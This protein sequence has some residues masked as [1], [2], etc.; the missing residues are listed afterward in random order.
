M[1][2][3]VCLCLRAYQHICMFVFFTSSI[4]FYTAYLVC[5]LQL[6][7][8]HLHIFLSWHLHIM[9]IFTW[10]QVTFSWTSS[11]KSLASANH[12]TMD[13]IHNTSEYLYTPTRSRANHRLV[14]PRRITHADDP[15]WICK[16]KCSDFN[17]GQVTWPLILNCE[18]PWLRASATSQCRV[19]IGM[20]MAI[21]EGP[22][23]THGFD[24][25]STLFFPPVIWWRRNVK[26]PL[27]Q[28][29][30]PCLIIPPDR[31]PCP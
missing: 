5:L 1:F 22:W 27:V 6:K 15:S 24:E 25:Q 12:T 21:P 8:W 28:H 10:S 17:V 26:A 4:T 30:V 16:V 29:F 19:R 9:N 20:S 13:H 23:I 31:K 7:P 11:C 18:M 2:L 14:L 3:Y